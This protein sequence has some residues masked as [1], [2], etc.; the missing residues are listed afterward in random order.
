MET[1]LVKMLLRGESPWGEIVER[2]PDGSANI[3]IDSKLWNE[4]DESE[5]RKVGF[6]DIRT[7]HGYKQGDVVLCDMHP[8]YE[9]WMPV[10]DLRE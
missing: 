9:K 2:L 10:A 5:R 6:A 4:W 1:G 8:E 7:C 3:R